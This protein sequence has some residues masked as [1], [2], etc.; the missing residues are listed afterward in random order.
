MCLDENVLKLLEQ[1]HFTEQT[2][3]NRSS[4]WEAYAVSKGDTKLYKIKIHHL[5]F[6]S[7]VI[8]ILTLL[9]FLWLVT[10]AC[11]VY[12]LAGATATPAHTQMLFE[13]MCSR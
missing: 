6:S 3:F 5:V 4:N 8:I 12:R 9:K 2:R 7:L 13:V 10:D 1:K 11:L